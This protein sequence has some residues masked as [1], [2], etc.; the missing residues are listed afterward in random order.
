LQPYAKEFFATFDLRVLDAPTKK[1]RTEVEKRLSEDPLVSKAFS[2]YVSEVDSYKRL[3]DRLFQSINRTAKGAPSGAAVDLWQPFAERDC[4]LL[5]PHGRVGILLPSAFHANQ[6]A[7]GLRE[8]FLTKT[9]L[10]K[11]FSF[12]NQKALFDIHRSFKFATVVAE[13]DDGGTKRVSCAFYRHD[14]EWLAAPTT[15]WNTRENS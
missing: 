3:L 7:T 14:L 8:L 15:R 6:S 4:L 10:A 1:E 11:C 9:R 5:Q 13:R 12:E 2:A